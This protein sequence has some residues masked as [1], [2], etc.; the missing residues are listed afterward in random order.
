MSEEKA[1]NT[2]ILKD[3]RWAGLLKEVRQ[4]PLDA[5]EWDLV[6][7]FADQI[8]LVVGEKLQEREAGRLQLQQALDQLWNNHE[9]A[10]ECFDLD[11][12]NWQAT[13]C[14]IEQVAERTG[15]VKDLLAQLAQCQALD[16]QSPRTFPERRK[17]SADLNAV[18]ERINSLMEQLNQD[19]FA[20]APEPAPTLDEDA[21]EDDHPPEPPGLGKDPS[22]KRPDSDQEQ[23]TEVD[24]SL[25]KESP[26]E[27]TSPSEE[28]TDAQAE[29]PKPTPIQAAL[30][31]PLSTDADPASD[32]EV[33]LR[34]AQEVAI[35]LQ[36]E[37]LDE[38]WESLGWALLA[39]GDWAGAYWLAR[40]L[41]AA[42]RG[43]PVSHELL[44][45]L[46]CSRWLH[47]DTDE[48]VFD[49]QHIASEWAPGNTAPERLLGF[50]A[51][52]RPTLVAPLAGLVGWLPQRNEINPALGAL[53]DAVRTFAKFGHPLR[54][55][56]LRGV[57]GM[58][59]RTTTIEET[60]EEA[61]HWL[62]ANQARKLKMQRATKVLKHLIGP[63]GDLRLL[64]NPVIENQADKIDQV[65]QSMSDFSNREHI[66]ERVH[67]IDQLTPRARP[68]TGAPRE[69]LVRSVQEAIALAHRWCSLIEEE[70][71]MH[72]HEDWWSVHVEDLRRQVQ[73]S[74]PEVESEFN[75]MQSG[76][77]QEETALGRVLH[78]ILDQ[79][80]GTLGLAVQPEADGFEAWMKRGG[81]LEEALAR[82]LL[83][84]PEIPLDER[85]HPERD[86]E[87]DIAE[88]L[89]RQL[90]EQRSLNDAISL[91]I[92]GQDF[93]FTDSLLDALENDEFRQACESQKEEAL[94]GARAALADRIEEVR[95][96]IE[97]AVVDGLLLEEDRAG[98]CAEL[99]TEAMEE[100]LYLQPLFKQLDEIEQ[101]LVKRYKERLQELENQWRSMRKTLEQSAHADHLNAVET[102]I[103]QAFKQRDTR[104]LEESLAHLRGV[105]QGQ[106]KWE[107][108]WFAPPD[109][110]DV[111][112][113]FLT[114]CPEIESGLQSLVSV[115]T[116]AEEIKHGKS[117]KGMEFGDLPQTRREETSRCSA[118]G[119]DSSADMDSRQK[120]VDM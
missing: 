73:D 39:E 44:A 46:Q 95:G 115:E 31:E 20:S 53:A 105:L 75:R 69:Q 106:R 64:L 52:L 81:S 48:L 102:F 16:D 10:L 101:Q 113:E 11:L 79:E 56:D 78:L 17:R 103:Q 19:F 30:P 67:Q 117:W 86:C 8:Q 93:R 15:K 108:E 35:L 50:A 80:K 60:V 72:G 14:P 76:A 24:T 114:A 33:P 107:G 85:G 51:A 83:L 42:G 70:R 110:R 66:V 118:L 12:S 28:K 63:N 89:L 61:R 34:S 116:L 29:E 22:D 98:L 45:V 91:R 94:K 27:E 18:H 92:E 87:A 5:P 111:F 112:G 21:E 58:T 6:Q 96:T 7:A 1:H 38:H 3:T 90:S 59:I 104:V 25:S 26:Q 54:A 88:A 82:R 62:E 4:W 68:I 99:E 36:K 47:S 74:L 120:P 109:E 65:H 9:E 100:P 23:E 57:E 71:A 84:I 41:T 13:D 119:T 55:K 97:Q 32:K 2:E 43:V 49:I 77:L 37:D 40:S